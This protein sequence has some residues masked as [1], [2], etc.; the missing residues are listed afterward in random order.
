MKARY[1]ITYEI[2]GAQHKA[3]RIATSATAAIEK[4]AWQYGQRF[5]EVR[6]VDA[7]T[8]GREWAQVAV[9]AGRGHQ[10]WMYTAF[11]KRIEEE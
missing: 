3:V 10:G 8:R 9:Y 6:L 7:D 2:N 11:V 1:Q 5:T 4:Y